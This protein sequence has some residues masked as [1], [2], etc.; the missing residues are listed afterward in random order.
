MSLIVM[1]QTIDYL[2]ESN[3]IEILNKLMGSS[4]DWD[5]I[6]IENGPTYYKKNTL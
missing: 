6:Q 1:K 3:Q 5:I 4:E 2:V